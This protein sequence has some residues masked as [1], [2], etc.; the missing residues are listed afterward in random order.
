MLRRPVEE[1]EGVLLSASPPLLYRAIK[2]NINAGRWL[3]ALELAQG[4]V[5]RGAHCDTVLCYRA[6]HL[7]AVGGGSGGAAAVETLAPFLAASATLP[8]ARGDWPA[9][10]A[11][12]DAEKARERE[13]AGAGALPW[14]A[15]VE[16]GSVGAVAVGGSPGGV[17]RAGGGDGAAE[18]KR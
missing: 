13:R 14:V 9:V 11:R 4:P 3:R 10:K 16:F 5:G 6:R 12:K 8:T 2:L 1:A 15:Y 7:E 18:G 17:G